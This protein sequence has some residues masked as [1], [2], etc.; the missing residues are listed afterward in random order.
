MKKIFALLAM[1]T[2]SSILF[3]QKAGSKITFDTVDLNG[4]AVTDAIFKE[5]K[6]TMLNIWGTFC[7]PCIREMPDLAKLNEANKSKG[8]QVVGIPIDIL[9]QTGKVFPKKKATAD[10]IINS[11]GAHYTHI[12]PNYGM[13]STFLRSIQ[14]VPATIF[15]DSNGNQIGQMYL[16]ARSQQDWQKIIDKLLKDAN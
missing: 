4:N 8:L 1:I 6:I 2:L 5:N 13:M 10:E 14:A 7:P 11:T 12:I 9:D 16:G 3:A 15:V